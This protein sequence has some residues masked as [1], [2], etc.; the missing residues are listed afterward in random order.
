[1][2]ISDG[3]YNEIKQ[4]VPIR[5]LFPDCLFLGTVV[6]F[7]VIHYVPGLGF[8]GDDWD[9]LGKL[10]NS[11]NQRFFG[12][13]R[14]LYN[15]STVGGSMRPL[16]FLYLAALYRLFGPRPLG[17]HI[18]NS[19]VLVSIGVLFY[20]V[21]RELGHHRF[22]ALALPL[23]YVLL[24][25]YS[26]DRFWI[27]SFQ[28]SLSMTLYFLS[29]YAALRALRAQSAR[30]RSWTLLSVLSLLCSALSY[31]VATPLFLLNIVLVWY[32]KRQLD[33]L[34][35]S[36]PL[37][38]RTVSMILG[39][40]LI[41]L[42]GVA[43][44]K[45]L[46][47]TRYHPR[48]RHVIAWILTAPGH[49][50]K[51]HYFDYGIRLPRIVWWI[52]RDYRDG[53]VCVLGGVLGLA[54]FWYLYR[55]AIRSRMM[56]PSPISMV[57]LA[58]CGL[59]VFGM[60]YSIFLTAPEQVGF[61]TTGI[62]N[63]TAIAASVGL[64]M[65]LVGGLG[66]ASSLLLSIRWRRELFCGLLALLCTSG[67]LTNNTIA[68]FWLAA[69]RQ[70]KQVLA[71]IRQ[72]LPS[73]PSHTVLILDGVCPYIGPGIVFECY[74]DTG[75]ALKMLYHDPTLEGDVITRKLKVEDQGLVTRIYGWERRYPYGRGLILY[76]FARK[77][78]HELSD[79]ETARHYFWTFNPDYGNGCPRG[80][81][82]L[83]VPLFF[84]PYKQLVTA[85]PA[86]G[87]RLSRFPLQVSGGRTHVMPPA[88]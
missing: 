2:P 58:A 42:M 50:L 5:T 22:W 83:G 51:I 20:L 39:S 12:L 70:Q 74:W 18:I 54:V 14:S 53:T 48:P 81:E 49:A 44:F 57:K 56:L 25:N 80:A 87:V 31:E 65:S 68:S 1:M 9:F 72:E 26:T 79:V 28:A 38:R 73:L 15:P 29:L 13:F 32:R 21:V 17:Y 85:V 4:C 59:V 47:T 7:S 23:V 66:W 41:A 55:V 77:T 34:A 64:A 76:N 36:Q 3:S 52:L 10:S 62:N 27:A 35:P 19:V 40:N 82:S 69:Y 75:G 78:V 71:G 37:S 88:S 61:S 60:G 30:F 16:Q 86:D 33:S 6:L 84:A 63:R 24:P 8:Y 46:T 45:L 43:A 11:S 67:F